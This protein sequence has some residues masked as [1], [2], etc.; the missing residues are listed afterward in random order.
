MAPCPRPGM[1][2]WKA[3][4][5]ASIQTVTLTMLSRQW[6][7]QIFTRLIPEQSAWWSFVI[8][9]VDHSYPFHIPILW[10]DSLRPGTSLPLGSMQTIP[11]TTLTRVSDM[12]LVRPTPGPSLWHSFIIIS[13]LRQ[14]L[15]VG[16]SQIPFIYMEGCFGT[17][18]VSLA[19]CSMQTMQWAIPRGIWVNE[20]WVSYY[21]F[22]S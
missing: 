4:S 3:F 7:V 9:L 19:L 6:G 20:Y 12:L 10:R 17:N 1:D 16:D 14:L 11:L 15:H 8:E 22:Y 21:Y 13:W 2:A 5:L 18:G